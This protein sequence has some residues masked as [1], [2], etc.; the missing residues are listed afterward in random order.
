METY[1]FILEKCTPEFYKTLGLHFPYERRHLAIHEYRKKCQQLGS[2]SAD[3]PQFGTTTIPLY[4]LDSIKELLYTHLKEKAQELLSNTHCIILVASSMYMVIKALSRRAFDEILCTSYNLVSHIYNLAQQF[5][6]SLSQQLDTAITMCTNL[7][8]PIF[9]L[10]EARDTAQYAPAPTGVPADPRPKAVH[11]ILITLVAVGSLF[12]MGSATNITKAANA[13]THAR[14][15]T[16]TLVEYIFILFGVDL[17]GTHNLQQTV[18]ALEKEGRRLTTMP[19]KSFAGVYVAQARDWLKR[20]DTLVRM[21]RPQNFNTSVLVS[22]HSELTKRVTETDQAMLECK[23]RPVPF[24]VYLY[25]D[26]GQGKTESIMSYIVPSLSKTFNLQGP[27]AEVYDL[28][29]SKYFRPIRGEAF[30][31]VDEFKAASNKNDTGEYTQIINKVVSGGIATIPTAGLEGKTQ[32]AAFNGIFF[33]SNKHHSE[34]D[35]GLN[36][37]AKNAFTSRFHTFKVVDPN[38]IPGNGRTNQMHRQP[39]FSHLEFLYVPSKLV[40]AGSTTP[41]NPLVHKVKGKDVKTK[42]HG[43]QTVVPFTIEEVIQFLIFQ[44]EENQQNFE[45]LRNIAPANIPATFQLWT[46]HTEMEEVMEL[47]GDQA[48]AGFKGGPNVFWITGEPGVG[49]TTTYKPLLRAFAENFLLPVY[50]VRSIRD[51]Y[52]EIPLSQGNYGFK[53]VN[54]LRPNSVLILDD[55][56]DPSTTEGQR[57]YARLYDSLPHTAIM[58]IFSNYGRM[59]YSSYLPAF[60]T[61]TKIKDIPDVGVP[62][63]YR[64]TNIKT[65]F[66]YQVGTFGLYNARAGL[67]ESTSKEGMANSLWN[68]FLHVILQEEV[69]WKSV[70]TLP[71]YNWD[72]DIFLDSDSPSIQE[73]ANAI[74]T[75]GIIHYPRLATG[76]ASIILNSNTEPATSVCSKIVNYVRNSNSTIKVRICVGERK[77]AYAHNVIYHSHTI[78]SGIDFHEKDFEVD[79]M[80][81]KFTIPVDTLHKHQTYGHTLVTEPYHYVILNQLRLNEPILWNK[82]ITRYPLGWREQYDR[83]KRLAYDKIL[84]VLEE[85]PYTIL[86]SFM[87]IIAAAAT[88]YMF[89]SNSGGFRPCLFCSK[90]KLEECPFDRDVAEKGKAKGSKSKYTH[91]KAIKVRGQLIYKEDCENFI[92]VERL[93]LGIANH[94]R[95]GLKQCRVSTGVF[96]YDCRYDENSMRWVADYVDVAQASMMDDPVIR[97][98]QAN[99]VRVTSANNDF[100][101]LLFLNAEVAVVPRHWLLT[102]RPWKIEPLSGL[103]GYTLDVLFEDPSR[104]VVALVPTK[105][106][107]R[108]L[109]PGVKDIT[110]HIPSLD[111]IRSIDQATIMSAVSH[112]IYPMLT[113][114]YEY[115]EKIA[116][117][118]DSALIHWGINAGLVAFGD[119]P[120]FTRLGDCGLPVIGHIAGE[121]YI[122]GQHAVQS[123]IQSKYGSIVLC[124]ELVSEIKEALRKS[125]PKRDVIQYSPSIDTEISKINTDVTYPSEFVKCIREKPPGP[126]YHPSGAVRTVG[127]INNPKPMDSKSKKNFYNDFP[128]T[129]RTFKP[130]IPALTESEILMYHSDKIPEDAHGLKYVHLIKSKRLETNYFLADL[131]PELIPNSIAAAEH[132]KLMLYKPDRILNPLSIDDAIN[133]NYTCGPILPRTSAGVVMRMMFNAAHKSDL[134]EIYYKD[135]D[136]LRQNPRYKLKPHVEDLTN[137]QYEMMKEGKILMLPADANLKSENLLVGKEWKKRVFYNVPLPTIINFK[138]IIAPLQHALQQLGFRSPFLFSLYPLADWDDMAA[139]LL[140]V[141]NNFVCLDVSNFDHSANAAAILANADFVWTFYENR[142]NPASRIRLKTLIQTMHQMLAFMHIIYNDTIVTKEGGVPSGTFGTSIEDALIW[143]QML[144]DAWTNLTECTITEFMEHTRFFLCGDDLI[145]SVHD[146]FINSFNSITISEYIKDRWNMDIT[147][148]LDKNGKLKPFVPLE[149]ASFCSNQ[150]ARLD[151]HPEVHVPKIKSESLY[152]AL[153]YS[154]CVTK[155]DRYEQYLM[156]RT[157]I[158]VYGRKLYDSYENE[159]ALFAKNAGLIHTPKVYRQTIEDIWQVVISPDKKAIIREDKAILAA[160][161]APE[162]RTM[163]KAIMKEL[164]NTLRER[165]YQSISYE[166]YMQRFSHLEEQSQLCALYTHNLID[167]S[168]MGPY[169]IPGTSTIVQAIRCNTMASYAALFNYPSDMVDAILIPWLSSRP[170]YGDSVRCKRYNMIRKVHISLAYVRGLDTSQ[171]PDAPHNPVDAWECAREILQ[172]DPSNIGNA[173]AIEPEI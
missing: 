97:A 77:F 46:P 7:L 81:S 156:Q 123:Q 169:A 52:V 132:Y 43:A 165:A 84:S 110:R 117:F 103:D 140:E 10:Y 124:S 89:R 29:E 42:T 33:S 108:T 13:I 163:S 39:D 164:R 88:W 20:T 51:G 115:R 148:A 99:L 160:L 139:T 66:H 79:V 15:V 14:T 167:F 80:G 126:V 50:E 131:V 17:T 5:N 35:I 41:Y 172:T 6:I 129:T 4:L 18:D 2:I 63:F 101:H 69:S 130:K 114:K 83:F 86:M 78:S 34:M 111:I 91:F 135:N 116:P 102:P 173:L 93:W 133:S 36:A 142:D 109:F 162:I 121:K 107:K 76:V 168:E 61:G 27:R 70:D 158:A 68:H 22:L 112:N 136:P 151:F 147:P 31:F 67:I 113:Q 119:I 146:N 137:L 94:A 32:T 28:S 106:G 38:Y 55:V 72:V 96:D 125:I 56:V 122:I 44:L 54:K 71:D 37:D 45:K 48:Q 21:V 87:V 138:R 92:D 58:I 157:N 153:M 24:G 154:H 25:G 73:I 161:R 145:M 85:H 9:D 118:A 149:E 155:A 49:K 98:A 12:G 159:L 134:M 57:A 26:P 47:K 152:G 143:L 127:Y 19:S 60:I 59:G 3:I 128:E 120:N 40:G 144:L 166:A 65:K 30:A 11:G 82:L 75:A 90:Y 95:A 141:G 150:F 171:T 100:I 62:G 1:K 8:K 105:N 170:L 104:E 16:D 23:N 74:R 53:P 64:R